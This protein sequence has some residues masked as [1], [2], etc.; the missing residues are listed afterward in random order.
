MCSTGSGGGLLGE[1]GWTGVGPDCLG[2]GTE[3]GIT[4]GAECGTTDSGDVVSCGMECGPP[5]LAPR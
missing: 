1:A 2:A 3:A 4:A 5:R